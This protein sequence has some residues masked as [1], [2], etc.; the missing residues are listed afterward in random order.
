VLREEEGR[1]VIKRCFEACGLEVVVDYPL[2]D[3]GLPVVLD[4]YDP[5]RRVGYE[6]ITSEAGDRLELTPVVVAELER[7]VAAGAFAVLLVDERDV[8]DEAELEA[9]TRRFLDEARKR[10]FVPT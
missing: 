7:R 10:G 5:M 2:H 1:A 4:G 9:A 3:V 8:R 6:Y